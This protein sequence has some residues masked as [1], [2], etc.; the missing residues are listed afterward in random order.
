MLHSAHVQNYEEI[1]ESFLSLRVP[2]RPAVEVKPSYQP[3]AASFEHVQPLPRQVFGQ[4]S[5]QRV[6]V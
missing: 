4:Q 2:L 5:P 3:C 6:H 1:L